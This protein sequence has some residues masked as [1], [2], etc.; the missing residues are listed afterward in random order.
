MEV[1]S[2]ILALLLFLATIAGAQGVADT[3]DYLEGGILERQ[4]QTG[5]TGLLRGS[6]YCVQSTVVNGGLEMVGATLSIIDGDTVGQVLRWNGTDWVPRLIIFPAADGGVDTVYNGLTDRDTA[7][8]L[9][10]PLVEHTT[11]TGQQAYDF[12]VNNM[13]TVL[14][15]AQRTSGVAFSSI[16]LGSTAAAG[17]DFAHYN[18]ADNQK[19]AVAAVNYSTGNVVKIQDSATNGTYFQ[20][21]DNGGGL[22]QTDITSSNGA[23]SKTIRVNRDAVFIINLEALDIT[24]EAAFMM[25]DTFTGELKYKSPADFAGL[26][27]DDWGSQAVSSTARFS[28]VGTVGSPL[29]LAQQSAATG[30]ILRWNGSA[31]APGYGGLVDSAYN[32][33]TKV[34]WASRYLKLGGPQTENTTITGGTGTYTFTMSGHSRHTFSVRNV[35]GDITSVLNLGS[36]SA[37]SNLTVTNVASDQESRF[38]LNG[39]NTCAFTQKSI[40]TNDVYRTLCSYGLSVIE[41]IPPS[42]PANSVQLGVNSTGI[43]QQNMR[44]RTWG[45]TV[46]CTGISGSEIIKRPITAFDQNYSDD[47]TTSTT[48]GGDLNGTYPNPTVDGLQGNAVSASAPSTNQVLKWN[49]S[50]WAPAADDSGTGTVTSV[51]AT[52]GSGISISGSPIT[53]S[54]TFV[55]TNTGDTNGADDITTASNG[56]TKSGA[57][58]KAGG[59]LTENTVIDGKSTY[60]LTIDSTNYFY[61]QAVQLGG[62]A[63]GYILLGS[64]LF[65]SNTEFGQYNPASPGEASVLRLNYSVGNTLQMA[66]ATGPQ[67]KV[68]QTIDGTDYNTAIVSSSAT[69][70][71]SLRVYPEKIEMDALSRIGT[72]DHAGVMMYDTSSKELKYQSPAILFSGFSQNLSLAGQSLGISGGTGVTLPIV[73]V[74]AGTGISVSTVAGV[75]TV[76]NTGDTDASNDITTSTTAGG[77]LNGTYPNPT[78]DG[79]QGNAVSASSPSTNQVLKWDGSAWAPST[80]A[81]GGSGTVTSVAATAGTGISIS[82]SPITTSGTFTI[83]NTG[84]TDASNDLTTSTSF[85]GDVSGLYNNL[86][87]GAN[88]VTTAEI[89]ASTITGSD[90]A[91]ATITAANIA[92]D[93]IGTNQIVNDGVETQDILDGTIQSVDI[94]TGAVYGTNIQDYEVSSTKMTTTGVTAATYGSSLNHPAI[95]VDAAGRITSASQTAW[96]SNVYVVS[97][98]VTYLQ[99]NENDRVARVSGSGGGLVVG[100]GTNL[101]DLVPYYLI[102]DQNDTNTITFQCPGGSAF[103]FTDVLGGSVDIFVAAVAGHYTLIKDGTTYILSN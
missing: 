96:T 66:S 65:S 44:L 84:D 91:N 3:C 89:A 61:A 87:L 97:G 59:D 4:M 29:E 15:E 40:S 73:G 76:T 2:K 48:A 34:P 56:L 86:Q 98:G 51:A 50:A 90:I 36:N 79:L 35:A 57:N 23:D 102:C 71:M 80:D 33:I 45:D 68:F 63:A 47:I 14:I 43:M 93:A 5:I 78:V 22:F 8:V 30:Q 94:A 60:S 99:L 83:T 27:G 9:G 18:E 70:T 21:Y 67:T 38:T 24:N 55:I 25:I 6:G 75:A 82:G 77:D 92:N 41:H 64:D 58:V 62:D 42:G 52:A 54:G 19:Q 49:G 81:T 12:Y 20:Q 31:W 85:S 13:R 88:V 10:G 17:V 101:Y 69:E 39:T 11:I 1:R 28:G 37:G 46:L 7:F 95:T 16:T 72:G 100:L 74:S 26:Y 53:T 32:G 103:K